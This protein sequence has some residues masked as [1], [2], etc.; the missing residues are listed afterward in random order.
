MTESPSNRRRRIAVVT[1]TRAEYGLL[2]PVMRAIASH[3]SLNLRAV[4]TGTHL[5]GAEPTINEI[6][7]EFKIAAS[8]PMQELAGGGTLGGRLADARALGAGVSH[9]QG[10]AAEQANEPLARQVLDCAAAR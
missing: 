5:L 2:R 6:K 8:F 4:V 3:P 9:K 7:S 1:G 10:G